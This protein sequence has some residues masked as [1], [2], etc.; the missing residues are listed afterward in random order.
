MEAALNAAL[1]VADQATFSIEE[2]AVAPYKFS[3]ESYQESYRFED[4]VEERSRSAAF[5]RCGSPIA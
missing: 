3:P 1:A 2:V 5:R 4:V